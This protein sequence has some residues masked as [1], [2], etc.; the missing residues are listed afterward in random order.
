MDMTC[1]ESAGST[2]RS[3]APRKKLPVNMGRG[4]E[5]VDVWELSHRHTSFCGFAKGASQ[6]RTTPRVYVSLCDIGL[7]RAIRYLSVAVSTRYGDLLRTV[8]N[9][10]LTRHFH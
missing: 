4:A 5:A 3:R 2:N 10:R 6:N 7:R 1:L 9:K 8:A